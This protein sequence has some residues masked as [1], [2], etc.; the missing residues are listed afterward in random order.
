MYQYAIK[1]KKKKMKKILITLVIFI[2]C[3]AGFA[4]AFYWTPLTICEARSFKRI[5]VYGSVGTNF[6]LTDYSDNSTTIDGVNWNIG[7][8][9]QHGPLRVDVQYWNSGK[10]LQRSF[11]L[12]GHAT[13]RFHGGELIINF[14]PLSLL[15]IGVG[16]GV[17]DADFKGSHE[18]QN[19]SFS[20]DLQLYPTM[21]IGTE[22]PVGRVV[23]LFL[24]WQFRADLSG[25]KFDYYLPT[26]TFVGYDKADWINSLSLGVRFSALY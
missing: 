25:R 4:Q 9:T 11:L 5:A 7:L 14:Q 24:N 2:Y 26:Q 23:S 16:A 17:I 18:N 3:S 22:I 13:G 1:H 6:L 8:L 15:Y 21:Q 20:Q 12:P 19:I 10:V